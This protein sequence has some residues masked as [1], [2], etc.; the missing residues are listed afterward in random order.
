MRSV[1]ISSRRLAR[2]PN[3]VKGEQLVR[4][5]SMISG[6]LAR[7]LDMLAEKLTKED[8]YDKVY[9][10]TDAVKRAIRDGLKANGIE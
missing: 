2:R 5:S 4:L 9:T 1:A 7:K 10:R 6:E 8:P 3:K